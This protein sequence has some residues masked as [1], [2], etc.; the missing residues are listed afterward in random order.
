MITD[1]VVVQPSTRLKSHTCT[2][3]SEITAEITVYLVLVCTLVHVPL[4]S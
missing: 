2:P 3:M 1:S 4:A